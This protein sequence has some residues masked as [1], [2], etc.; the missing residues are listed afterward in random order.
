MIQINNLHLHA[1]IVSVPVVH[2]IHKYANH[3][4]NTTNFK[5]QNILNTMH[6]CIIIIIQL[7]LKILHGIYINAQ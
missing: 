3:L 2:S 5:L 1:N 4:L 6:T 7:Q